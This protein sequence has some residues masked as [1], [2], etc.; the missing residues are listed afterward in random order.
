M[1]IYRDLKSAGI[2][3]DNHESDLYAL[4]TPKSEA[5]IANYEHR[6]IVH[7]F[8]SQTDKKLWFDIPFAFDPFWQKKTG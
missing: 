7:R 5:I 1:T 6:S 8:I 3:L 2:P 4:V